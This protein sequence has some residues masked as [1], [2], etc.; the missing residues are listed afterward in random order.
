MIKIIAAFVAGMF[1][2]TVGVSGVANAFD[3]MVGKTTE[4]MKETVK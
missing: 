2:A 4:V 3:K 1:V